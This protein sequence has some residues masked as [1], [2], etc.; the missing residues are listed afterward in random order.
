MF[1]F[2]LV[3]GSK[4]LSGPSTQTLRHV[5]TKAFLA[6]TQMS[7]TKAENHMYL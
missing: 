6:M 2:P 7:A 1:S 3:S 4:N 5:H